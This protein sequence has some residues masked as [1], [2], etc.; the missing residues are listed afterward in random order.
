MLIRQRISRML[1][2]NPEHVHINV[3]YAKIHLF[4]YIFSLIT[5]KLGPLARLGF[6][7]GRVYLDNRQHKHHCSFW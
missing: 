7:T 5:K 6:G 4:M 2:K 3:Q 1:M